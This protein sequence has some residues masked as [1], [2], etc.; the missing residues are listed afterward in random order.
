[1]TIEFSDMTNHL[2]GYNPKNEIVMQLLSQVYVLNDEKKMMDVLGNLPKIL[3]ID[4]VK[5]ILTYIADSGHYI[6]PK[7]KTIHVSDEIM[8]KLATSKLVEIT[9]MEVK[10]MQEGI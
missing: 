8:K 1:M 9:S 3:P 10:R 5:N 2:K 7:D 4:D 6:C